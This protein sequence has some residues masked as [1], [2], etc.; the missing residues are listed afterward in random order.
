MFSKKSILFFVL[1]LTLVQYEVNAQTP[2]DE[3]NTPERPGSF[4]PKGKR[5]DSLQ[6]RD[7]L[8]DSITLYYKY[9]NSNELSKLDTSIN[10]F[11]IHYPIPYT[12]YNL[13]NLGNASKSYLFNPIT[14]AGWDAGFH[15]YDTYFYT[16]AQTPFYE[17]TRPYTE[18][19]YLLG[20]KGEQL[21]EIKHTQNNKQQFNFSFDYRFSNAP[22]SLKNQSANLNN[23]RI[24]A[25]FQSKRKRYESFFIMLVNKAA[26]SENGGLV[27][28]AL[29]DSL[30]LNNPYELETRL[31]VSGA[32]F[33]NPF[34]TSIA[35]G[36]IYKSNT[37]LW[38]QTYD[39]GQKDS[40]VK[41]TI[42]THLFYPRLRFQNEIKVQTSQY[43]FQD[44][45]PSEVNYLKYFDITLGDLKVIQYS[46]NWTVLTNEFSLISY[47][48]KNNSNQFL[49]LGVGYSQMTG[50]FAGLANWNNYNLYTVGVYKNKTRN[51]LWDLLAS[52]KL[53]LNG[54]HSGDYEASFG[55]SR[56]LN[57]KGNY[58]SLSFQN[59]NRTPSLNVL[60]LTAFP[61]NANIGIQK[62]NT[63]S[64]TGKLGNL[65]SAFKAELNYQ[66]I[67]NYQ[68]FSTG[69]QPA[70]NANSM[71][72]IRAQVEHKIK[73]S[74]HW[75]WYNEMTAQIIDAAAPINLPLLLTRQRVAYEG[76]FYKNLNLSTGV[77][78]IYH[79]N[80]KPDAYMPFTGQFYLQNN[81][82]LANRPTVN[83]FM[84]F[85][86]KRFKGYVRLEN[87]N[88]LL[89]SNETLGNAYNFS[90]KNYPGPGVWFRVGI[91]WNFIN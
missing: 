81:Y 48:Q 89:P 36:S 43:L 62:E 38:K 12:A 75:N 30:A 15:S 79:T 91:W 18:F 9:Y 34:N 61:I 73:I 57:K 40:I 49:Q 24:T 5:T 2:I 22:G 31:G 29:L 37:F 84:H 69:F 71:S 47:P 35:T 46:D 70:V 67:N 53:F 7:Q 86:I 45:N 17:T 88:T 23:M 26:S 90:A 52:G 28:A 82:T 59:T 14:T 19:A 87:L 60:G 25:H 50:K 68:Y 66:L 56:I 58:L 11:F 85:I 20:G 51:Q 77:E 78:L 8:A 32:S 27:N 83:A 80:Y 65:K 13:G 3:F 41:D 39:L 33:R 74:K 72:Y 6:K 1:L 55:L 54:Y 16:L 10:D 63:I 44:N 64:F 4:S 21:V 76:N 42:V